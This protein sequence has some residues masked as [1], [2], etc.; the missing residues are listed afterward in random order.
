MTVAP[1]SAPAI[2]AQAETIDAARFEKAKDLLHSLSNTVSAM[3]IFP[4]DHATIKGFV[5]V[6]TQKFTGFL[7]VYQKLQIGIE[8][9]AFTVGGKPAFLDEVA[10]KSLPFFF[11]KDGLQI[12][13]FYQGIERQEIQEFLE[14]IKDEAQKPAEDSDIV[15]A[16]WERD[17]PNIQ[18][19]APEEFLETRILAESRDSRAIKD[20]AD[21]PDDLAQETIE[22]RVDTSKFSQGQIALDPEDQEQVARGRARAEGDE[23]ASS[24]AP[25]E[26][27]G[28]A[29]ATG[30]EERGA[31][32][33]AAA[34]DPTLTEEEIR[35]LES[36]VRA[37]RTISPE[38]E[39]VN[40]MV[41]IVFLEESLASCR[42]TLDALLEYHFEQLQRGQFH[43]AVLIIEKIH[44]L[45]R[46]LGGNPV[47]AALLDEFLKRTVSPQTI[48]AVKAL[49]AKKKTMDWESLL[50]FFTLLGPPA[51]GLA[52]DLF[53]I[54]PDGEARHKVIGFIERTGANNLGLIAGLADNARPGLAREIVSIL[55]RVPDNRGIPHLAAFLNFQSKEVKLEVV[56]ILARARDEMANRIL[57]G[58]LNDPDE[59]IRILAAMKLDPGEGGVRVQQILREVAGREFRAKSLKEKEALLSFLGRTRTPEALSFLSKAL[60]RAPL[61]APKKDLETRLAAV[62]GLSGM[63][64]RDALGALQ[65]GALGRTKMVRN[66]CKAALL[67]LPPA[68]SAESKES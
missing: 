11:F 2:P 67:A 34:M 51:L 15:A 49:L 52:A 9:Y 7:A 53:G 45:G 56:H 33:P 21:L 35:S 8:E 4:S 42:A 19:Y 6:L 43:V 54:A 17:F 39:Y 65:K 26:D 37:N 55:A 40:L 16:L 30:P 22:V 10:I 1:K 50:G 18:Y 38:E 25:A 64:T 31:K 46:Q 68:G 47:K 62:A 48:D 27:L 14:L 3:K 61:F 44:E 5:D 58:F 24:P 29:T 13:F 63:G 41:E 23:A 20:I 12:L 57:A 28:P 59:E 66:A 32:S 36:M 60:L